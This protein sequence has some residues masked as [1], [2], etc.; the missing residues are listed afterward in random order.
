MAI[1]TE[2]S[3]NLSSVGATNITHPIITFRVVMTRRAEES[4]G[5]ITNLRTGTVLHPDR[6]DS[7]VERGIENSAE[8]ENQFQP[9]IPGFLRGSNIVRNDDGTF[10]AYGQAASYLKTQYADIDNPLL[11]VT[12]SP[13]YTSA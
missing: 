5:P 2:Y 11:V 9:F 1:P 13:P 12:N 8:H 7:D 6:Y 3:D 10:T 4:I